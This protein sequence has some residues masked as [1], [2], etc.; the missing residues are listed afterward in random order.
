M[1]MSSADSPPPFFC[2]TG[3]TPPSTGSKSGRVPGDRLALA[4]SKRAEDVT[5]GNEW[6]ECL[7]ELVQV[8]QRECVTFLED[9]CID[10][11]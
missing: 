7:E 5:F 6:R 10:H 3:T 4:F 11:V 9:A 8:L 1:D 2:G